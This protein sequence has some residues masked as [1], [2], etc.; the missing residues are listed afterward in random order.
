MLLATLLPLWGCSA[1][2]RLPGDA[3]E[4]REVLTE[5]FEFAALCVADGQPVREQDIL[6]QNFKLRDFF[7]ADTGARQRTVALTYRV[8][9]RER[10]VGDGE[11]VLWIVGAGEHGALHGIKCLPPTPPHMQAIR[12]ALSEKEGRTGVSLGGP[13]RLIAMGEPIPITLQVFCRIDTTTTLWSDFQNGVI[14][15]S[16][17]GM[18]EPTIVH[19]RGERSALPVEFWNHGP[20]VTFDIAQLHDQLPHGRKHTI[21]LR[22]RG[23]VQIGSRAAKPVE[24]RSNIVHFS[25]R[26]PSS[27][28]F[29]TRSGGLA[30]GF[31][32]DRSA[33][34]QNEWL[35]VDCAFDFDRATAL[36]GVNAFDRADAIS[37]TTFEFTNEATGE[38]F[39][40]Q[41]FVF[42]FP[43][44]C[45]PDD[46][47]YLMKTPVVMCSMDLQLVSRETN[48]PPGEYRVIATYE[49]DRGSLLYGCWD[50]N[51]PPVLWRGRVE[52]KP[53]SLRVLVPEY[54]STALWINSSYEY[55]DGGWY[56][57]E[58]DPIV[59]DTQ[60]RFG[61]VLGIQQTNFVILPSGAPER[62]TI[63][64]HS[65]VWLTGGAHFGSKARDHD[66]VYSD[67]T[68]FETS[69]HQVH[70][71]QPEAGDY[72]ILWQ[73]RIHGRR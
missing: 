17:E 48:I 22:W 31:E 33:V 30:C 27:L 61:Y 45:E 67:V 5:K 43:R 35:Q 58:K 38:V 4:L 56:F 36:R 34:P 19:L 10:A 68:L 72:R 65:G 54:E 46:A 28:E 55:R 32:F 51:E 71:W 3:L 15:A 73:G 6:R 63:G 42:Q 53:R 49:S 60:I 13:G 14:E 18:T 16:I 69:N 1:P 29:G 20:E 12:H 66:R 41:P 7:G 9:R 24:L 47:A 37:S 70:H 2:D 21:D 57:S 39:E 62:V 59:V 8:A 11:R 25:I 40:H 50:R 23:D 64:I 26:D 52:S 44:S